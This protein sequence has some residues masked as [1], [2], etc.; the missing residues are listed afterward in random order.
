MI[1]NIFIIGIDGA[2]N[3]PL[4]PLICPNIHRISKN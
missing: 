2:G 4:D 3:A 1:K